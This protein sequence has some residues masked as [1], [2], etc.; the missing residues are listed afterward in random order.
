LAA[1]F[2]AT[3]HGGLAAVS[4]LLAVGMALVTWLA[5]REAGRRTEALA[6]RLRQIGED[7]QHDQRLSPASEGD[8][9][10]ATPVNALLDDIER[11]GEALREVQRDAD[12][13]VDEDTRSLQIERNDAEA[14]SLAKTR[15][16]A[17]M[18][19]ELRTPLNGVIGAA[20]LLQAGGQGGEEQA[21]LIEAIC[22]SGANLLG[23]IENIL[24]LSRI[25]T[26]R[27]ELS[28]ADFDLLDCIET[29]LASTAVGARLKRLDMACVVDPALVV[30]RHGDGLRLRQILLNLLGNA[31]KF[32]QLGEVVLTLRAGD[33][34]ELVRISVQDTGI[35]IEPEAQAHVFDPFQQADDTVHRR[36]GGSGLGLTITRQLVEAMNGR[37]KVRSAPG[38]GSR[39]DVELPLA[40][41]QSPPP[42][43]EPLGLTV[44]IFEPHEASAMALASQLERLGCR[45]V[46]CRDE[47]DLRRGLAQCAEQSATPPWLLVATDADEAWPF[48]EAAAPWI[49]PARVVGM[50]QVESPRAEAARERLR[51]PVSIVK[52]VLR[53]ALVQRLSAVP[54]GAVSGPRAAP[55]A[56]DPIT[57]PAALGSKHV[58]VVEDDRLNQTIVCSMLQNAGYTTTSAEGGAEALALMARHIFD[59]V[60]MDWHMPDM[61]GLQVTRRIRAGEAGRYGRIVPIV[62]LTANAFAE[63]RAACLEAGMNDFLTKPVLAAKLIETTRRWTALP[64]G[65]DEAFTN[66]NFADLY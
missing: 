61:D 62:A 54:K 40:L 10:I 16:L 7:R 38:Q 12:R 50:T 59:L 37:I 11:L 57:V 48:M 30:A 42:P 19:H 5:A 8:I 45:A 49:D 65:D 6:E 39:F 32:T 63:D 4:G 26:G 33:T 51:L 47:H 27:F 53:A 1:L 2:A 3:G 44:L 28:C 13:R 34:P 41:A 31:V 23:L 15:F 29:S 25:E 56:S 20:Q 9:D 58:L 35:G 60:L 17:N 64:G 66:S 43:A 22:S 18:S 52:P 46:R 21:H 24:D 36:F 14:A 55:M